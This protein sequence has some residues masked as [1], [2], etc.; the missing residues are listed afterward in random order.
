MNKLIEAIVDNRLRNH[1]KD[2]IGN[3]YG[4]HCTREDLMKMLNEAYKIGRDEG[5]NAALEENDA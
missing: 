1:S 2:S 3:V 5:Y 4:F